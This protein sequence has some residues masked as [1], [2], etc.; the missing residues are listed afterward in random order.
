MKELPWKGIDDTGSEVTGMLREFGLDEIIE[1]MGSLLDGKSA[2]SRGREIKPEDTDRICDGIGRPINV[3][4]ASRK[5]HCTDVMLVLGCGWGDLKQ[6]L[7]RG[8]LD[9]SLLCRKEDGSLTHSCLFIVGTEWPI[10]AAEEEIVP[11][12][13]AL[14]KCMV[15]NYVLLR[16]G[17]GWKAFQI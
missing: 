6:N 5:G 7:M 3:R 1:D 15:R 4:P 13:E 16:A 8:L 12:L 10:V 14:N 17:G 9:I 11:Y 2:K